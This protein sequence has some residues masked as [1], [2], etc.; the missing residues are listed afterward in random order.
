M[1]GWN[2]LLGPARS[3]RLKVDGRLRVRRT[4]EAECIKLRILTRRTTAFD[5]A[6][7]PGCSK[8]LLLGAPLLGFHSNSDSGWSPRNHRVCS[9][10]DAS[11]LWYNSFHAEQAASESG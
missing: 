8:E 6:L 7:N 2:L 11:W 3:Y 5:Q 1:A 4:N 9:V 10:F